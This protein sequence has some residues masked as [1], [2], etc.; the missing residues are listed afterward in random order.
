MEPF[1]FKSSNNE[2]KIMTHNHTTWEL[3]YFDAISDIG[4]AVTISFFRDR[5]K[6]PLHA[7]TGF[8][9]QIHAVWEDNTTFAKEHF[10][11]D[12]LIER[13]EGSSTTQGI[14][15]GDNPS[16]VRCAFE[17]REDLSAA[18]LSFDSSEVK[19]RVELHGTLQGAP[20]ESAGSQDDDYALVAPTVYW[21]HQLPTACVK[22]SLDLNGRELAFTGTGG[23]EHWWSPM[24]WM[25][26]MEESVFLRM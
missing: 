6:S 18:V 9:V 22:V 1:S 19:G 16:N 11:V 23:H 21:A 12:S 5:G 4:E 26:I 7:E 25:G 20:S 3:W 10:C 14:W 17:I 24:S 8:R 13:A 2:P 15:Q